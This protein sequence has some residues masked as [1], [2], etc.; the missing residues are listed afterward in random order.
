MESLR[1]YLAFTGT[2]SSAS[3]ETMAGRCSQFGNKKD[4]SM[5]WNLGQEYTKIQ[6]LIALHSLANGRPLLASI[7][8]LFHG[9]SIH[10]RPLFLSS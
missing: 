9:R 8:T 10:N 4:T 3:K 5:L 2:R 1:G 7:K 6:L